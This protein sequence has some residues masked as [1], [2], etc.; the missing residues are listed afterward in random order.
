MESSPYCQHKH[1]APTCPV[2]AV[3]AREWKK[4]RDRVAELE[5]KIDAR[6]AVIENLVAVCMDASKQCSVEAGIV[7]GLGRTSGSKMTLDTADA[8]SDLAAEIGKKLKAALE[9]AAAL[10]YGKSGEVSGA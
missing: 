4:L 5:A 6:D 3:E 2:C 7:R 10:G 1:H 9:S 8:I